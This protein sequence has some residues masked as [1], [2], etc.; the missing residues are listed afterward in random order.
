VTNRLDSCWHWIRV[1]GD[2]T[3]FECPFG[4]LLQA[5][6]LRAGISL[7]FSWMGSWATVRRKTVADGREQLQRFAIGAG[8]C[9]ADICHRRPGLQ[10]RNFLDHHPLAHTQVKFS[11]VDP[12]HHAEKGGV[13]GGAVTLGFG[14][15]A[16]AQRPQLALGQLLQLIF[17]SFVAA[18][19]H[20]HGHGRAS[21]HEGLT[22][23]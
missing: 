5:T 16:T 10:D 17:K 19:S 2:E 12:I 8:A 13:A 3:A 22:M 21:Q 11:G 6:V 18:S 23:S 4:Q 20:E 15:L 1:G 14:I 9:P 7:L